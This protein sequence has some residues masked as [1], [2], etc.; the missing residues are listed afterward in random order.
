MRNIIGLLLAGILIYSG[1]TA[2]A[3]IFQTQPVTENHGSTLSGYVYSLPQTTLKIRVEIVI[4]RTIRGPYYRFAEKYMGIENVPAESNIEWSLAG[5]RL[6]P[7]TEADPAAWFLIKS[8]SGTPDLSAI[9]APGI[10]G[11]VTGRN[12]SGEENPAAEYLDR[13]TPG[14][15]YYKDLSI[16]PNVVLSSD[17]LYKTILTDTSFVKVPVLQDQLLVRTIDEK[18]REAADLIFKLR[19]R[20]FHMISANY[21][22]MPEGVAMEHALKELDELEEEYLSLFIGK[23]L[24]QRETL[25]F[26]FTPSA[27]EDSEH[28]DLFGISKNNGVVSGG[29]RDAET[30]SLTVIREGKTAFL[31]GNMQGELRPSLTN[32]IYY[33][34]P[35]MAR[36]NVFLGNQKLIM[37]RIPVYQYGAVLSMPFGSGE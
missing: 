34:V 3:D 33:R 22:I 10:E 13:S 19:K 26:Y 14:T 25:T 8:V 30:V 2:P 9:I 35:D 23:T 4:T 1:C 18:A 21:D 37:D 24:T 29:S 7:I 15:L 6:E 20:R 5:V 16:H 11:F 36:V 31:H 27:G 12:M 28:V 32:A 17:T